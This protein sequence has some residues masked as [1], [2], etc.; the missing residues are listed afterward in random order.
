VR[1]NAREPTGEERQL[2]NPVA[3]AG[4][5]LVIALFVLMVIWAAHESAAATAFVATCLGLLIVVPLLVRGP[6]E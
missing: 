5:L 3:A 2:R 6:K 1:E 4:W